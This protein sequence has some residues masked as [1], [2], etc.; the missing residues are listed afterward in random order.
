MLLSEFV[1]L[2]TP[3]ANIG[4]CALLFW[5]TYV[6]DNLVK[7]QHEIIIMLHKSFN[8]QCIE[9]LKLKLQGLQE[10]K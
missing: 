1:E 9:N 10:E 2:A 7:K 8:D 5:Q 6:Y 3:I 4:L